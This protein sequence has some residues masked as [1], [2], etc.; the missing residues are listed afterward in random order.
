[1]QLRIALILL[2]IGLALMGRVRDN[3][4]RNDGADKLLDKVKDS[5]D[6]KIEE[7]RLIRQLADANQLPLDLGD[8]Y[9]RD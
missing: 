7:I 3:R 1:M 9:R 8:K 2:Q 4:L 5:L 6:E